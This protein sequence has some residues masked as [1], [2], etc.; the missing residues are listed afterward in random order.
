MSIESKLANAKFLDDNK[1][2]W[3]CLPDASTRTKKYQNG[4]LIGV[5]GPQMSPCSL[6]S[7]GGNS[8]D[9]LHREGL[10]INLPCTQALHKVM[11]LTLA[12]CRL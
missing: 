9:N 4:P 3:D 12:G 7:M 8:W 5:I 11:E 1:E 10:A 6:E 2:T